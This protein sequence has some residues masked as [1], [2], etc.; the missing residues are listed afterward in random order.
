M[1][2]SNCLLCCTW[3]GFLK[4]SAVSSDQQLGGAGHTLACHDENK[5]VSQW[6]KSITMWA[7]PAVCRESWGVCTVPQELEHGHTGHKVFVVPRRASVCIL[8]ALVS[9]LWLLVELPPC[10]CLKVSW[11]SGVS[12]QTHSGSL[13]MVLRFLSCIVLRLEHWE[14][15]GR[16]TALW[17]TTKH[18]QCWARLMSK[19]RLEHLPLGGCPVASH[20]ISQYSYYPALLLQRNNSTSHC[21]DNGKFMM[22]LQWVIA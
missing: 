17:E 9:H 16:G 21:S 2:Q 7:K 15:W 12:A 14:S 3:P 1:Y 18:S 19:T 5:C 10:C 20:C 11:V 8:V 13:R 6:V 22:L 4:V